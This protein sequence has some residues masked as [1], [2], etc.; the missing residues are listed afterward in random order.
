MSVHDVGKIQINQNLAFLKKEW[1]VQ[2]LGWIAFALLAL[3]GLAGVLG[4]GPVAVQEAGD[5]AL[6]VEYEGILR[7]A[8]ISDLKITVGPSATADSMFRLYLSADYLAQFDVQ[9]VLPE[10]TAS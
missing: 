3:L 7:H 6:R 5:D 10:P 4:R 8:A 1:R 9:S 2:R